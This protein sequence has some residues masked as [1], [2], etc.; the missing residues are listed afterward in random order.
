MPSGSR[1]LSCASSRNSCGRTCSTTRS[2]GSVILRAASTAWRTSS[3][4]MS[5]GAVP[6]RDA[7]AAVH[8]ANVAAGDADDGAL[9][10]HAGDALGFFNRAPHRSRRRADI[11]DQSLA[12]ALGFR[13]AHGH[14]FRARFSQLR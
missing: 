4:L 12:Q 14:K 10:G 3:R 2:S 7:A 8:A 13:R 11:G 6:Q 5:R 9:D 1:I